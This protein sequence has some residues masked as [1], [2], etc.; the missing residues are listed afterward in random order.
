MRYDQSSRFV[1]AK[2][3]AGGSGHF[4]SGS[5]SLGADY[6]GS[7]VSE[8][9]RGGYDN[10]ARRFE[11]PAAAVASTAA[12]STVITRRVVQE[13]P[14]IRRD[15]RPPPP[16]P[17][18]PPRDRLDERRSVVARDDRYRYPEITDCHSKCS[19]TQC[20]FIQLEAVPFNSFAR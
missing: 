8:S 11:R 4:G 15:N 18:P 20:C 1:D 16:S 17:P 3:S 9:V 6:R 5:S 10:H 7:K 12:G 19:C 14:S 2:S 13:I